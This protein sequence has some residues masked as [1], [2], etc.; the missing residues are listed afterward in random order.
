MRVTSS[1]PRLMAEKNREAAA[2]HVTKAA[3]S[4]RLSVL[5]GTDCFPTWRMDGRSGSDKSIHHRRGADSDL[6]ETWMEK[7]EVCSA[8]VRD[9]DLLPQI[10]SKKKGK[11]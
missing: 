1:L 11:N 9:Y 7:D 3:A 2:M 5:P 4:R 8:G 6:G 10:A